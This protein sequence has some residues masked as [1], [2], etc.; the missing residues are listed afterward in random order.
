MSSMCACA[1]ACVP[2]MYGLV[3]RVRRA[4][5]GGLGR[6]DCAAVAAGSVRFYIDLHRDRERSERAVCL[7]ESWR[8]L[9]LSLPI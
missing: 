4:V 9:A 6:W 2:Y 5:W 3:S 7:G 1:V 8:V